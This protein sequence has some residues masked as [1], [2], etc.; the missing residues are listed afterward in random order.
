MASASNTA[1]LVKYM[2]VLCGVVSMIHRFSGFR[3][4]IGD[5]CAQPI[6]YALLKALYN[7]SPFH[8]LR[9]FPGPRLAAAT[10]L[11]IA[12]ASWNGSLS[13]WLKDLHERYSTDVVRIS[14]HELSFISPSAWK[15]MCGHRPGYVILS[16][17]MFLYLYRFRVVRHVAKAI[18]PL[19]V[20]H[21]SNLS[22][23]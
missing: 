23:K 10:Q 13:H 22:Q 9:K 20:Y 17:Q 4:L 18:Y 19:D 14:P 12:T 16:E 1:D 11:P 6:V 5:L 7:V 15:D 2:A 21:S 3:Q 8:P